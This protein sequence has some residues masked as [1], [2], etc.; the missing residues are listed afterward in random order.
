MQCASSMALPTYVACRAESRSLV[1]RL[2]DDLDIPGVPPALLSCYDADTH[3]AQ[4]D[5]QDELPEAGA[6]QAAALI[7]QTLQERTGSENGPLSSGRR[8]GVSLS[9]DGLI[10]PAG[11]EDAEF[12]PAS[13]QADLCSLSDQE[14]VL[15]LL[16]LMDEP[17]TQDRRRRLLELRDKSV[18]HDWLWMLCSAHGSCVAR[19]E[20][21]LAVRLRLGLPCADAAAPCARCGAPL[22]RFQSHA[23][24]CALPTTSAAR[25]CLWPISRILA[26]LWRLKVSF[27][28]RQ[29]FVL[30]IF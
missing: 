14:R 9:G 8:L 24:C 29:R 2:L 27:H 4:E 11:Y 23:F 1:V 25:S 19:N 26:P 7:N 6:T 12:D 28:L 13:L 30:L 18:S 5:L 15:Q 16:A 22:G 21:Q 10:L 17:E 20:F 3:A